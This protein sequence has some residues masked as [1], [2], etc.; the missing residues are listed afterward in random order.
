MGELDDKNNILTSS[1]F[2]RR[3]KKEYQEDEKV[4]PKIL[5]VFEEELFA[6]GHEYSFL[7][8]LVSINNNDR[9]KK[10]HSNLK[11]FR[12]RRHRLI[13]DSTIPSMLSSS[14]SVFFFFI[15]LFNYEKQHAFAIYAT[16]LFQTPLSSSKLSVFPIFHQ[17]P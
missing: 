3:K 2:I 7:Q 12:G 13:S 5:Q 4:Y 14:L 1:C 8:V 17:C 10:K 11:Y 6:R 16:T 15:F 9:T